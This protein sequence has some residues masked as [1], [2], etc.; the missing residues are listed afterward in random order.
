V[1]LASLDSAQ[2]T[3]A[4][5]ST[6]VGGGILA[7]DTDGK[8]A[9]FFVT[10]GLA[11]K[12]NAHVHD[13]SGRGVA[14]GVILPLTG[15]TPSTPAGGS[16]LWVVPDNG[17]INATQVADFAAGRLYYN[18]HTQANPNGDIRGQLDRP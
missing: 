11:N 1:K 3:G 10:T 4:T 15:V 14:G 5:P 17:S 8:A 6:A 16:D 12:T 9:G 2:E 18:A 7:V 13:S